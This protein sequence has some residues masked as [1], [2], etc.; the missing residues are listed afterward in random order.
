MLKEAFSDNAI[1]LTQTFEWFKHFINGRMTVDDDKR[2][3]QPS[4]GTTTENVAKV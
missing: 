3:G 4:T 2:S 1:G